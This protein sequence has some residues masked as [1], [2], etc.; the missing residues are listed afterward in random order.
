MGR[1]GGSLAPTPSRDGGATDPPPQPIG[2]RPS[3]SLEDIVRRR[4]QLF[5]VFFLEFRG[6]KI[7]PPKR[8]FFSLL[9]RKDSCKV[10]HKVSKKGAYTQ[11]TPYSFFPKGAAGTRKCWTFEKLVPPDVWEGVVMGWGVG[12]SGQS[13][14]PHDPP[15]QVGGRGLPNLPP[16]STHPPS[17]HP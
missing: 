4:C 1:G 14:P 2:F 17:H 16:P 11:T 3:G 15:P 6:Q 12:S 5:F 9:R 13:P 10:W 8:L 7:P